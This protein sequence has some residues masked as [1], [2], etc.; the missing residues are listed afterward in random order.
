MKKK[1]LVSVA[2]LTFAVTMGINIK[3]NSSKNKITQLSLANVEALANESGGT[4][5]HTTPFNLHTGKC[6]NLNSEKC[7]PR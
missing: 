6:H 1:M 5:T 7:T 3:M 4:Q 2:I